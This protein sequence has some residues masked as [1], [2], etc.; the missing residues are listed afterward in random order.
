MQEVFFKVLAVEA[1][2]RFSGDSCRREAQAQVPTGPPPGPKLANSQTDAVYEIK[3]A[4][5]SSSSC[6]GPRGT[7]S[8]GH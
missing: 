6:A 1:K 3:L 2:G 4:P 7:L 8:R 5:T